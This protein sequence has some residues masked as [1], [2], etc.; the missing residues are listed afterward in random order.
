MT[1]TRVALLQRL[2]EQIGDWWTDTTTSIGNVNQ[3]ELIDTSLLK[4]TMGGDDDGFLDWWV[5]MTSGAASGETGR[6]SSSTASTGTLTFSS[7]FSARIASGVT[8]ELHR[9]DP[10]DK[11]NA[12][13]AAARLLYPSL[14]VPLMDETLV[15]DD[16]LSNPSFETA[17]DSGAHPSWTNF[18]T[19]ASV[20]IESNRVWHGSQA[21][22]Y[23][24]SGS[25][26]GGAQQ[27]LQDGSSTFINYHEITN[28]TI[29]FSRRVWC[30]TADTARIGISLDNGSTFTYSDYHSGAEDWERLSVNVA[31]DDPSTTA[32]NLDILVRLEVAISGTGIFDGGS[33][34]GAFIDPV[35]SYTLPST[36]IRNPQAVKLQVDD[37]HPNA[38]FRGL[39]VGQRPRQGQLIQ[40]SGLGILTQPSA[41]GG[42][43][44]INDPE[45]EL[46][47]SR[48]AQWLSTIYASPGRAG[49]EQSGVYRL[50]ANMWGAQVAQLRSIFSSHKHAFQK[51]AQ[52]RAGIW[53]T[54]P[55]SSGVLTL[56]FDGDR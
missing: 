43:M 1:T 46:L 15:V 27:T 13:N 4:H 31:I 40:V 37:D 18:G 54:E 44:E 21:A 29:F 38:P 7:A 30:A 24:A 55:A 14:A 41:D 8:Y 19:P 17:L 6:V 45:T 56:V 39:R 47:V 2:S 35:Y 12:L 36:F 16:L 5:R 48:A 26:V 53:H 28:K 25:A 42:T 22:R 32:G 9:F 11:H 52:N 3:K 23:T 51:G 34:T 10:A 49:Q 20:A 33:N 50:D